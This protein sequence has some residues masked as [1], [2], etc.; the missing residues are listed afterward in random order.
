M[1]FDFLTTG[2]FEMIDALL[3]VLYFNTFFKPKYKVIKICFIAILLGF[4]KKIF[5]LF[6]TYFTHEKEVT[7]SL[8]S[9]LTI[10]LIIIVSTLFIMTLYK[11]LFSIL[12]FMIAVFLIEGIVILFLKNTNL[13]A[14]QFFIYGDLITLII[15][16]I[17]FL[18][19]Y[20]IIR[21]HYQE[22][23]MLLIVLPKKFIAT[24]IAI[25]LCSIVFLA[26]T[27]HQFLF[28]TAISAYYLVFFIFF[29]L[30]INLLF[31]IV[32]LQISK[33]YSDLLKYRIEHDYLKA[34]NS[35]FSN[36]DSTMEKIR[37]QTHDLKNKY[38]VLLSMI[39]N[40]PVNH[41]IDYIESQLANFQQFT[42]VSYTTNSILN[43]FLIYKLS[44][45]EQLRITVDIKVLV[46]EDKKIPQDIFV[47]ILGNLIDN[48]VNACIKNP[49]DQKWISLMIKYIDDT[50]TIL[51]SNPVQEEDKKFKK[52]T[53]L[54]SIEIL[55]AEKSGV[56]VR[57]IEGNIFTSKVLLWLVEE[58]L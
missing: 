8:N 38:V 53:G 20:F 30:V 15:K 33:Y 56:Y 16:A 25:V 32:F 31:L 55:V 28:T 36:L 47:H 51:I 23:R 26:V 58:D 2:L 21:L 10:A 17:F 3:L 35:Y 1:I 4:L 39:K 44:Y 24:A 42:L 34:Q 27:L 22:K 49:D 29:I 19:L 57:E 52:G 13:N 9:L 37:I 43:N 7:Q 46:P 41:V 45:A 18:F 50:L 12:F 40:E 48:S 6:I 14:Q 54:R 5:L 11:K